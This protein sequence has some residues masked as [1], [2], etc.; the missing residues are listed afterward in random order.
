MSVIGQGEQPG[1]CVH[2]PRRETVLRCG[3]CGDYI[4]PQC[5]VQTPVGARCRS[6]AQLKRLPQYDVGLLLMLRSG[7][8]GLVTS[9]LV[10]LL[11]SFM[12]F[13][14]FFL[15]IL[16]GVAVG[17]AV[18]RLARRRVS[19]SLEVVAVVDVVLGLL[20]AEGIRLQDALYLFSAAQGQDQAFLLALGLPALI[21][22][23]VAVVKL[24]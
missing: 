14:R 18:S 1:R 4:C 6:C 13:L 15:S 8:A 7:L 20:L 23:F 9:T 19:R 11:I 21:A 2:H 16:V 24:R 10:W 17:E 3:K 22:S 12:P 5:T